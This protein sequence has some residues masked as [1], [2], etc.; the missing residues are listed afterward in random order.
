MGVRARSHRCLIWLAATI[1]LAPSPGLGRDR[2]LALPQKES[3]STRANHRIAK[4]SYR[5]RHL[6]FDFDTGNGSICP[7][8]VIKGAV[9]QSEPSG[10]AGGGGAPSITRRAGWLAASGTL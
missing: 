8:A 9:R 7:K 10:Q 1:A 3:L 5:S 6:P 2:R 4:G